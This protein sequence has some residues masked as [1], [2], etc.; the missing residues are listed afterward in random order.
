LPPSASISNPASVASGCALLTIPL[1]PT[2]GASDVFVLAAPSRRGS[3]SGS[4]TV[5]GVAVLSVVSS[6]ADLCVVVC[7]SG[8]A[9]GAADCWV[10]QETRT[11]TINTTKN[12]RINTRSK[13]TFRQKRVIA[14][15]AKNDGGTA[16][17]RA[18]TAACKGIDC[19]YHSGL[20]SSP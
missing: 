7:S 5:V 13:D 9:F 1:V 11:M 2:A 16:C 18:G 12:I 10:P 4:A 14:P 19:G 6:T 17:R 8:L 15:L 3:S 20:C